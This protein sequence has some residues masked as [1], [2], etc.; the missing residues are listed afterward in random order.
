MSKTARKK[1]RAPKEPEKKLSLGVG[2]KNFGPIA[3]GEI[4]LRPLTV[5]VGP[6]NS[7]KSFGALFVHSTLRA[8]TGITR[9]GDITDLVSEVFRRRE[10]DEMSQIREVNKPFRD[11]VRLL[12]DTSQNTVTDVQKALT[13]ILTADIFENIM[14]HYYKRELTAAF[15][16]SVES[17]V[18]SP[19]KRLEIDINFGQSSVKYGFV[20]KTSA[21]NLKQLSIPDL[22]ISV[23]T[24]SSNSSGPEII[25]TTNSLITWRS[26]TGE[27]GMVPMPDDRDSSYETDTAWLM[28]RWKLFKQLAT[29]LLGGSA[30]RSFYLPAAR[31]GISQG[32]KT[33]AAAIVN[34]ASVAGLSDFG[35]PRVSPSVATLISDM[36]SMGGEPGPFFDLSEQIEQEMTGGTIV[37]YMPSPGMFPEIKFKYDGGVISLQTCSSMISE[38]APL[39]LYLKYK[40]KPGDVLIVEEP[41]A[42]LHPKNQRIIAKLFARLIRQGVYVLITTHSE[43]LIQQIQNLISLSKIDSALRMKKYGYEKNDFLRQEE[44]GAYLF[45]WDRKSRGYK[46]KELTISDEE[47]VTEEGFG[48]VHDALYEETI[49]IERAIQ[50]KTGSTK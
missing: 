44:V 16:V 4:K 26:S 25:N 6:N 17:L 34:Q 12:R 14:P 15:G 28:A 40:V 41:E 18:R 24:G 22:E 1:T 50:E 29:A 20:K 27:S 42:H 32:Y 37:L 10:F 9:W 45:T 43:Y 11:K 19:N 5:L 38:L 8:M 49:G 2:L 39:F 13:E 47:G 7:G 21:F 23:Q 36:L 33:L 46:T 30:A 3:D 48:D 31:S 35:I